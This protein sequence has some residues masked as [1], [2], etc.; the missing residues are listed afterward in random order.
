MHGEPYNKLLV[1][2]ILYRDTTLGE[3]IQALF[4]EQGITI[5]SIITAIGMAISTLLFVITGGAGGVPSPP[6]P[7]TDKD[8]LED[9]VKETFG[10]P[11]KDPG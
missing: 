5:V 2:V 8:G 11:W 4:R 10:G 7:P 3:R 9:W 6:S 1:Q